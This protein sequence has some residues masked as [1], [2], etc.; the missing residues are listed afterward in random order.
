MCT[1]WCCDCLIVLS[2]Q[3]L[4][5]LPSV[6]HSSLRNSS[7]RRT[8]WL[9]T[10]SLSSDPIFLTI[11]VLLGK[12]CTG[13]LRY[14]FLYNR[15]TLA[16]PLKCQLN[17]HLKGN[18]VN[19]CYLSVMSDILQ[20]YVA[21]VL[22]VVLHL[23]DSAITCTANS[24]AGRWKGDTHREAEANTVQKALIQR[25]QLCLSHDAELLRE[26]MNSR[27]RGWRRL[28][29]DVGEWQV[30]QQ[31]QQRL[32]NEGKEEDDTTLKQQHR[33][34]AEDMKFWQSKK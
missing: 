3:F 10:L 4:Q 8:I 33:N 26:G 21:E 5:S 1:L 29:W 2:N 7:L 27:G 20:A 17:T 9:L 15:W 28:C 34:Q 23:L 31:Q 24:C 25:I 30:K 19:A 13:N 18:L 6:I 22:E 14:S 16:E 32:D 11:T 12:K